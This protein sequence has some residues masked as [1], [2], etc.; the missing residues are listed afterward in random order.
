MQFHTD[1]ENALIQKFRDAG[2]EL[3]FY[4]KHRKLQ[5]SKP[6]AVAL[7]RLVRSGHVMRHASGDFGWRTYRLRECYEAV[8]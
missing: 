6:M 1:D 3:M 2:G 4:V 7:A 5:L 8:E